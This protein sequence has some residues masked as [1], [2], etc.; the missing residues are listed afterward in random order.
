MKKTEVAPDTMEPQRLPRRAVLRCLALG[1]AVAAALSLKPASSQA[2]PPDGTASGQLPSQRLRRW[3]MIVDLRKCDGCQSVNKPPQCTEACIQGHYAPEPMEWVQVY[4]AEIP[5]GGTQFIPTPC[6]QCQNPPCTNLC[7]VGATFSTPEGPVLIDQERCIGCRIC[8]EGC[9][10][11][12]RF[13]NWG[14]P[15]QP[16]AARLTHYNPEDES[17]AYKGTVMKCDFCPD[18]AR[19]GRRPYCVQACPNGAMYYGDLEEDLATNGSQV[20]RFS[21]FLSDNAAYRLKEHLGTEPRVFYIPGYGQQV[22]RDARRRGR[23]ATKWPWKQ[24]IPGASAWRRNG[25]GGHW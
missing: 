11:D 22:G 14:Q 17:P 7:P 21:R 2:G 5:G 13:F 10:Y 16:P 4:E 1:G 15:P 8:M 6:Q 18:L 23:L 20:V 9:P 25:A 12:R 19:A 24:L 3:A